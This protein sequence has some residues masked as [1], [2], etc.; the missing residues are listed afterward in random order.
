MTKCSKE[1][2]Y[3]TA[4]N[5][6]DILRDVDPGSSE[7]SG[8]CNAQIYN[9]DLTNG[10]LSFVTR[11]SGSRN[12]W[13]QRIQLYDW[14][15]VIPEEEREFLE[16]NWDKIKADYPD[17][18]N[19]DLKLHCNCPSF[20]YSFHYLSDA[21]GYALEPQPNP[22]GSINPDNPRNPDLI[23]T[24]CKHLVSVLRTFFR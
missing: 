2:F 19:S 15:Y 10:S 22:P 18:L 6:D 4:L 13:E 24:V 17:L 3:I 14:N 16:A 21:M 20:M 9:I 1:V 11:C 5:A 7:R 8:G 12:T 23:G